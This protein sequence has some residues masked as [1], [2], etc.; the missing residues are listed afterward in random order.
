MRLVSVGVHPCDGC[1]VYHETYA[2]DGVRISPRLC[3][4]CWAIIGDAAAALNPR[5]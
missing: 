1:E 2:I 4:E 5:A 3:A